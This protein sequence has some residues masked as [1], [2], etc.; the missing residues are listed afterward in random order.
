MIMHA[1]PAPITATQPLTPPALERIVKKCL[2][3]EPDER[4]QSAKDLCDDLRW[5]EADRTKTSGTVTRRRPVT[6]TTAALVAAGATVAALITWALTRGT[7]APTLQPIRL[8]LVPPPEQSLSVSGS[9][10][11]FVLSRDGTRLV[12]VSG[13]SHALM[14]RAIERSDAVRLGDITGAR[15]P[16]LSPDGRWVGFFVGVSG[17]ELKKVAMT[18]GAA[19][20]LCRAPGGA[21]GASW[22][23]DDTIIFSTSAGRLLRVSASGGEPNVLT[24]PDPARGETGHVFPSLLPG[25]RAVLFTVTGAGESIDNAQIAVLDLKSGQ[26]KNLVRGGNQ[27]AYLETGHVVYAVAGAL[28]AIRF[29]AARLEVSGEPITVVDHVTTLMTGAAEFSVASSGALVYVAGGPVGVARS[30]AWVD[31]QG[32]ED[33]LPAPPRAYSYPRISPDGTRVALDIRDQ[34]NDIWI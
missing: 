34:N 19:T 25:S 29:D 20:L 32:H 16:F 22:G 27:A 10:R 1:D 28:R 24:T 26:R 14:V 2:A 13:S 11:D 4:W 18:G 3:K 5:I 8:T 17:T 6:A 30:L 12:Y 9:D 21:R 33:L 23:E 7:P 15:H 31:R